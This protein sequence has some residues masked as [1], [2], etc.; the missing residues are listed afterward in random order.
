MS[1]PPHPDRIK[2]IEVIRDLTH[3]HGPAEGPRR[4]RLR[5]P[6]VPVP[7]WHRWIKMTRDEDRDFIAE[8]AAAVPHPSRPPAPVTYGDRITMRRA[9]DFYSELDAMVADTRLLADYA[10]VTNDNGTRRV[11]NP[12]L[13]AVSHRMRATNLTIALKH[14]EM[15]WNVDRLEQMHDAIVRAI[16]QADREAGE[17]VFSALT[18]VVG[19]WNPDRSA[20]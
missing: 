15:V 17:R 20:P 19:R 2:A 8:A 14:S 9:I 1:R 16:L 6:D 13:L 5:F 18:E 3:Q 12:Q 7:T 4:A 11:K 10:V